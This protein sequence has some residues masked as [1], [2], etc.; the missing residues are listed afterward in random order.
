MLGHLAGR[1]TSLI[2][3]ALLVEPLLY[4][5]L[6]RAITGISDKS[7][8]ATLRSLQHDGLSRAE[9]RPWTTGPRTSARRARSKPPSPFA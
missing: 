9:D 5:A 4:H 7:L 8:A 2:R 1:W 3:T 6:R